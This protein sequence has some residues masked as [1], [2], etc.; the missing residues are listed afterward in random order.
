M[1]LV[2]AKMTFIAKKIIFFNILI[3]HEEIEV[4]DI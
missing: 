3:F 4:Q 2:S 1:G